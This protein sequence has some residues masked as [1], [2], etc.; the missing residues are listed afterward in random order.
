[1]LHQRFGRFSKTGACWVQVSAVNQNLFFLNPAG[2]FG[3]CRP[4]SPAPTLPRP[5]VRRLFHLSVP[6]PVKQQN[7]HSS[8]KE[9][10]MSDIAVLKFGGT[11]VKNIQRLRHVASIVEQRS[12]EQKV[13]VVVSAMG[14]T[15]DQLMRTAQQCCGAPAAAELDV[16]LATGEQVTIALLT[17][18]LNDANIRARSFTGAQIGIITDDRHTDA[19]ILSIDKNCINSAFA[20]FDVLVVAGFQGATKDGSITTLGRGGSDT[21]AVAIAAAINSK[22]CEIYTD[23]DGIYDSDPNL[24]SNAQKFS[25]ISFEDC[26]TLANSGAQVI[27]PRAVTKAREHQLPVRVRSTFCIADLGTLIGPAVEDR[28][29]WP[30][31]TVVPFD[32]APL[33]MAQA[34]A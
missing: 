7:I 31:L 14:D 5:A 19:D 18:L 4:I 17:M 24:H 25:D 29:E 20:N 10:Q 27:H 30:R 16:L 33:E 3:F 26:L 21:T 9:N 22:T 15:T 1:M 8:R 23:V 6:E 28:H 13:I 34:R 2:G 12:R 32:F 11:S